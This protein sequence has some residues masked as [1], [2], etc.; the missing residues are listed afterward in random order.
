MDDLH[1]DDKQGSEPKKVRGLAIAILVVL[2]AVAAVYH[3]ATRK[4]PEAPAA[5]Q[6]PR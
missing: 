6:T 1:F 3:F 5:L 2:A 4:K